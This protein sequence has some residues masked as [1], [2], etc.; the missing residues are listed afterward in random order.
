MGKSGISGLYAVTPDTPDTDRLCKIVGYALSSG[1]RCLQY[2]NKT[3]DHRLRLIQ[4]KAVQAVCRQYDVPLII[5][6][7]LDIAREIDA[8]GLHVG[9][10]DTPIIEARKLLGRNKIIGAS[11]YN[12][13]EWAIAAEKAGADY[14]AF[15][16]FYPSVTKT[17]TVQ[18]TATLLDQARKQLRI[19]IVAIGGINLN[20]AEILIMHGCDTIA[21]SQALFGAE[22]IRSTA[23]NFSRLFS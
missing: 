9:R 13:L 17:D 4:S 15:G 5:N 2:R 14:A 11:C 20:N 18:A 1:T 6:D 8:D 19:P 10:R 12:R 23:W 3:A 22:D 21:V 7:H 16:A